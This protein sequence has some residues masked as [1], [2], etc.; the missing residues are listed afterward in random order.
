MRKLKRHA[1][2]ITAA[3]RTEF[4]TVCLHRNHR[5]E[6]DVVARMPPQR[7]QLKFDALFLQAWEEERREEEENVGYSWVGADD[8][9]GGE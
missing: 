1:K 9:D 7:D 6:V 3:Q 2:Q 5:N 8:C 4:K